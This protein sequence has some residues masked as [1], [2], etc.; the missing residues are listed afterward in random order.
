MSIVD[1]VLSVTSPWAE[2][3]TCILNVMAEQLLLFRR[4]DE[5]K[6][7]FDEEEV[8]A[9]LGKL[10]QKQTLFEDLNEQILKLTEPENVENEI[11]DSD[12]YS[13][14]M[15]TKIRHIRKFIQN[16][17]TP[18]SRHID[19]HTT[20]HTLN[21][22]TIPFV[23]THNIANPHNAQSF[24]NPSVQ[25]SHT[26]NTQ[27]KYNPA[28]LLTRGIDADQY[29]NS[30]IWKKGP[31]WLTNRTKWPEITPTSKAVL[32]ITGENDDEEFLNN[33]VHTDNY[34]IGN[35]I[36]ISKYGTFRKLIRVTAY[37]HRFISNCR[38]TKH[39]RK[40]GVLTTNDINTAV[41]S[42]ILDCQKS[43]YSA[44][45]KSLQDT[46]NK[47]TM[48]YPRI[49]QLGLFIDD[50]GLVRC[51]GRIHN[52]PISENT[53]FPYLIPANQPLTKLIR[54]AHILLLGLFTVFVE[55]KV[56]VGKMNSYIQSLQI[57]SKTAEE[58]Y[59]S[60]KDEKTGNS[61]P[62]YRSDF[63]NF[64]TIGNSEKELKV[65]S[66]NQDKIVHGI[67][68]LQNKIDILPIKNEI[69][70]RSVDI[71]SCFRDLNYYLRQPE[72]KSRQD[73]IRKCADA[74]KPGIR[75]IAELLKESNTY[76]KV[77]GEIIE[78][79]KLC[80]VSKIM[81]MH[82]YLLSL[83]VTG[84]EAAI[85]SEVV[86]YNG[87]STNMLEEC[88][89]NFQDINAHLMDIFRE[90]TNDPCDTVI[91]VLNSSILLN[92]DKHAKVIWQDVTS[93]FPWF[94]FQI[95]E[96][97]VKPNVTIVGNKNPAL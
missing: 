95:Y 89:T 29:I 58:L 26:F 64:S 2:I 11:I 31:N 81:G 78:T 84:C 67:E 50:D 4:L 73:N 87:T 71:N 52:A 55:G 36:D 75:F 96:F 51:N 24:E 82:K 53:K 37:V 88:N 76:T 35:I 32:T 1:V 27:Q 23:P 49:R 85:T 77:F 13:V 8:I 93:Y 7:N 48:K 70:T 68:N 14:D 86:E 83:F 65:L 15:E 44:E 5:A 66:E 3:R 25:A 60:L 61:E 9:T 97:S 10:V 19:S 91:S 41:R 59:E 34:G 69:T 12:E 39:L 92:I 72:M 56:S 63:R 20:T 18:Q 40:S 38:F 79:D 28:D 90:C 46:R 43:S 47:N 42:W 17:Q 94:H 74:I 6:E 16:V 45:I 30:V 21:P 22:E 54:C 57:V 62:V 33:D 80:N